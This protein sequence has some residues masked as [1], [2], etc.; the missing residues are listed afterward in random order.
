MGCSERR[1]PQLGELGR[2]HF[3]LQRERGELDPALEPKDNLEVAPERPPPR[4]S[5]RSAR[6]SGRP[7]VQRKKALRNAYAHP[8]C[9]SRPPTVAMDS[10]M[11]WPIGGCVA[12]A[13]V[14]E[15]A[16]PASGRG[17][18]HRPRFRHESRLRPESARLHSKHG[19]GVLHARSAGS[20]TS[21]TFATSWPPSQNHNLLLYCWIGLATGS[22][23]GHFPTCDAPFPDV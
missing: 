5:R 13:S 17:A 8:G 19:E 6:T 15:A 12:A 4:L 20:S 18:V 23:F 10:A 16:D 7:A 2:G 3:Q 21:R 11:A 22:V 1:V 9:Y 14:V